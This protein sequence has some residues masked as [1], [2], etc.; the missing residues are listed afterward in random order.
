[1]E[2]GRVRRKGL[3]GVEGQVVAIPCVDGAEFQVAYEF[4]YGSV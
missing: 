2:M 3:P 1:M 4:T